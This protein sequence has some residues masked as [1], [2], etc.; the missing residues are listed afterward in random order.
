MSSQGSSAST[1]HVKQLFRERVTQ[2]LAALMSQERMQVIVLLACVLALDGADKSTVGAVATQLEAALNI[3]NTAVGLLV[4]ASTG[5]GAIA[6]LPMGLLVDRFN[7]KRLLT[8]AIVIWSL[9]MIVSGFSGS[10]LMLLFTRLALG[11]IV[12]TAA[13]AVASMTGDFFP[14]FE[15]GRIWGYLLAGE[16]V[17]T[18]FGF[19]VSGAIA[20]LVSWR[21]AFWFLGLIGFVLAVVVWRRLPEPARGGHARL[22]PY[23]MGSLSQHTGEDPQEDQ[24][25]QIEKEIE[26]ESIPAHKHKILRRNPARLSFWQS[27]VYVLSIRTNVLLIIASALGYFYF[28]GVRTF[29][30]VFMAGRFSLPTATASLIT[31]GLGLGSIIGVFL[32]GWLADR[33]IARG[34]IT[35]R[36]VI[37]GLAFLLLVVFFLPALLT[38]SLLITA[39]LF[40]L[41]ALALGGTNPPL[42]AARLDIMH[43]RL[44]GRAESIRTSLRYVF[45]AI[46][47]LAFG[48]ISGLFGA[49]GGAYG[50]TKSHIQQGA[51]G[52]DYAF[53]ILL[54]MPLVAGIILIATRHSYP[55]D[56]ATALASEHATPDSEDDSY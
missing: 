31:V 23:R 42:D 3:G 4:T 32:T 46:A 18:A 40:F 29:G 25:E 9:A 56:T 27:V 48:Y 39:P 53:L 33:L 21:G 10:Y 47:P 7:R 6:T 38:T 2:P 41:A 37:A 35:A 49:S 14:S 5:I 55:R 24:K 36:V 34:Q 20:G 16:L 22:P 8:A 44:W 1:Q 54:V 28:T 26:A 12:A 17:G 52:L 11:A 15:R 19:V 43:S 51:I 45:E 30:V 13:P 50:P